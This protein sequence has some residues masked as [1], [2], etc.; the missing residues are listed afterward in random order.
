M[1]LGDGGPDRSTVLP[2]SLPEVVVSLRREF[3]SLAVVIWARHQ[4]SRWARCPVL[5]SYLS[6]TWLM[7]RAPYVH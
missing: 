3:F 2:L 6:C 7:R 4:S 5:E 1:N